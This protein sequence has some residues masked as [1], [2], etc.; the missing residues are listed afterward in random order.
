MRTPD[1]LLAE[2]SRRI[3]AIERTTHGLTGDQHDARDHSAALATA[4]LDDLGDVEVA[5]GSLQNGSVLTYD[6]TKWV[7]RNGPRGLIT[8]TFVSANE[9]TFT[10]T[11]VD[12]A[13]LSVTWTTLT[14][15]RY[16]VHARIYVQSSVAGDEVLVTVNESSANTLL[17]RARI[18][19]STANVP[20]EADVF[21]PIAFAV[22]G[23]ASVKVRASRSAGSGNITS[24]ASVFS[25]AF[26]SVVDQGLVPA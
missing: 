16:M 18:R 24:V 4:A 26:V 20:Y 1:E 15:R 8:E 13:G 11:A 22:A 17:G 25:P 2:L 19:C 9:G 23:S 14:G 21:V 3:S 10:T 5:S 6:G 7:N 12:L